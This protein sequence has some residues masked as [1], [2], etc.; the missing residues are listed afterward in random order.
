M[1]EADERLDNMTQAFQP[2]ALNNSTYQHRIH[3][4]EAA[5]NGFV[6]EFPSKFTDKMYVRHASS[7]PFVRIGSFNAEQTLC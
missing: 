4:K 6:L 1:E 2:L 5:V 7:G 3:L